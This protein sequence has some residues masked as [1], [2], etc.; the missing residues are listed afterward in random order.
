MRPG[1]GTEFV[2]SDNAGEAHEISDRVFVSAPGAA[3]SD[4]GEPLAL[5]RDISQSMKLGSGQQPSGGDDFCRELV[6]HGRQLV[7]RFTT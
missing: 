6:A 4:I 3:V 1:D 2:R 5:R 7:R